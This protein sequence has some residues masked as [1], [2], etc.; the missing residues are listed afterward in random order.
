MV[1]NI[2]VSG[3]TLTGKT[4]VVLAL[5]KHLKEKGMKVGYLK[6]VGRQDDEDAAVMKQVLDM[7]TPT[8]VICPIHRIG[9]SFDELL[10]IGA[11]KLQEQLAQSYNEVG[12]GKDVVLIEGPKAPWNLMHVNLSAPEL[13]NMFAAHVI[14]LVNFPDVS[15]IDDILL[16]QSLFKSEEGKKIYIVLNMVP[17]ML[18]NTVEEKVTA[19]VTENGM[20]LLGTIFTNRELFSPT[21]GE[22]LESLDGQMVLGE[23]KLNL[24][25]D[26]FMVG[27]MGPENALKWFRRA[28]DK[29]VITSGDR[30]DICLAAM[31]TDT[32]LL[33]LTGGVG[34]EIRTLS[35]AREIG[36]P[37]MMTAYDTYTTSKIVDSLLGTVSSKNL[38]KV[39][40]I[41][42]IVGNALDFS[43]LDL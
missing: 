39:P 20:T 36:I 41:E 4:M 29:A 25:I 23:D 28:K 15:A 2:V 16:Q 14:C 8:E 38:G 21:I 19:F 40:I 6:P 9:S 31:E 32:N 24:T 1:A 30:A 3:E 34:P 10:K 43:R 35:H 18:K 26:Q 5:A 17:P 37:I 13:V 33:I 12:K 22:I 7:D 42:K 27:S 11:K